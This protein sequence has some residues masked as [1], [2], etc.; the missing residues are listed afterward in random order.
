MGAA[1]DPFWLV[2]ARVLWVLLPTYLAN[3]GATFSRGRG[4]PMDLGRVWPRD[5]RRILGPSKTWLGFVVGTLFAL[6]FGLLEQWL[7]SIAPPNLAVVPRFAPTLLA[8][9]APVLLLAA[10]GLAGDALG[11]FA[12]RRFDVPSGGRALALDPLGFVFVPVALGL[13]L[14]PALFVP[15]FFS[16][17][18]FAWLLGFTLGLHAGFNWV[19]YWVG[20]KRVPW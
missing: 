1:V 5:G 4:P 8:A 20:L 9:V 16:A 12:K 13:A 7:V 14:D 15:T 19:G 6:P 11:S 3:A 10:G 17:E 18:A 2:A